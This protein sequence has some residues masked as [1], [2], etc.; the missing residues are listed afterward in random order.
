MIFCANP[1]SQYLARKDEIDIAIAEVLDSSQYVLGE[2]VANFEYNFASFIGVD[3]CVGVANGTDALELALRSLE[4][5]SND[6][7]IT[8][9]HTAVATVSAIQL[10]GATPVLVDVDE[11]SYTLDPSILADAITPKTK[12]IIAVHL[13]GHACDLDAILEIANSHNIPVIEDVSQAHAGE[14]KERKLGTYGLMSCFSCYPTKNL[15][16]IGDAGVVCTDHPDIASKV[17]MLREYGWK[18]RYLSE[19]T[20]RNSRLDEL[21][22]AILSV[23][24]KY[25]DNDTTKRIEIA[26]LYKENL[27]KCPLVLPV[28][29]HNVKH[30]Y[31]LFAILTDRRDELL[32]YLNERNIFPGIHYPYPIHLQKGYKNLIKTVEPLTVTERIASQELSLPLYP[33]LSHDEVLHVCETIS[34]F[35]CQ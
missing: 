21:Q 19:I 2:Q 22:A 10:V 30:A 25:L 8:V 28:E 32:S 24:L 35:Y 13:Y 26:N 9:S 3:Y 17:R 15:G 12:A 20:G 1:R 16:A 29:K 31:H 14:Y 5:S 11:K 27:Q 4:I 7:V 18:E 23:K 33:E 34:E 6:E